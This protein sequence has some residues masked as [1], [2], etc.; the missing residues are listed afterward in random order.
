MSDSALTRCEAL[1]CK[2]DEAAD[3]HQRTR[4]ALDGSLRDLK[5]RLKALQD[6][7]KR[8]S[9]L[10]PSVFARRAEWRLSNIAALR[11]TPRNESMWS[12]EFCI[13]G[14]QGLQL[15]FFPKGRESTLP[16][17]CSLF[18][19]CH[20]D[21]TVKYQ[22]RVGSHYTSPDEDRFAFHRGHGHSNMCF[23]EDEIDP[24]TDSLVVGVEVLDVRRVDESQAGLKLFTDSPEALVST[25]AAA[26]HSLPTL[27][28]EWR[29]R[30]CRR[31]ASEV[32]RGFAICSRPFSIAGIASVLLELYPN[33]VESTSKEGYCGF[34]FRC[35]PGTSVVVSLFVGSFQKGPSRTE[36]D[37]NAAKGFPEFCP[38]ADQLTE[39]GDLVVGLKIKKPDSAEMQRKVLELTS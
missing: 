12:P 1:S 6:R 8:H 5:R 3:E 18:L 21:V 28:V 14:I 35:P 27:A 10:H 22:L 11:D 2:L 31:R 33:G 20:P 19:W 38:L 16:G 23:L 13:F 34:Y 15:E 37:A 30:D 17:F 36:F 29:I 7:E 25:Q 39:D 26:M 24:E 32:P 9:T 4:V